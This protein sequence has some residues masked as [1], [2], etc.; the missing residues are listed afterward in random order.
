MRGVTPVS[1][2]GSVGGT[3]S[4]GDRAGGGSGGRSIV[5]VGGAS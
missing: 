5:V 4:A 3:R 1:G 2:S